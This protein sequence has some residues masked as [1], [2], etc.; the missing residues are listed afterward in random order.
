MRRRKRKLNR[1]STVKSF[2]VSYWSHINVSGVCDVFF[3]LEFCLAKYHLKLENFCHNVKIIIHFIFGRDNMSLKLK[4][5]EGRPNGIFRKRHRAQLKSEETR[6]CLLYILRLSFEESH[7]ISLC[8]L[9]HWKQQR[10]PCAVQ[11]HFQ[12]RFNLQNHSG[13]QTC[14]S[15][16]WSK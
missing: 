15:R 10:V 3:K 2:S 9:K 14:G 4:N 7:Q 16:K 8:K 6:D 13:G 5:T 1:F 12:F 11:G